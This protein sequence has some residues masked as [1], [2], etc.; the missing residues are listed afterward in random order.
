MREAIESAELL[1]PVVGSFS[2]GKS[3]LINA[4]IGRDLL[5]VGIK[6][7]T[8]LATELRHAEQERLEA[9]TRDGRTLSF[10]IEEMASLK[11]RAA[12]FS[13]LRLWI[14]SDALARIAPL[15]LVDMP[16]F[17]ST[18]ENHNKA[19]A[20][21]IEK[22]THYL[23]V[24]SVESGGIT[25]SLERQI[26]DIHELGRDFSLVLSKTNLRADS[27]VDEVVAKIEEQAE[28]AFGS[29]RTVQ[30]I[31][32][33][34][35]AQFSATLSAIEPERI[36]Q[37]LFGAEVKRTYFEITES[38]N[39]TLAALKSSSSDNADAVDAMASHLLKIERKREDLIAD[40]EARYSASAV[41]RCVEEVGRA[42][43]QNM[44]ELVEAGMSTNRDALSRAVT[45][46][47][48]GTLIRKIKSQM[49]EIGQKIVADFSLE[50]GDIDA[51]M[52]AYTSDGEWASHV[53]A[54]ASQL[55]EQAGHGFNRLGKILSDKDKAKAI[56]RVATTIVA[57]TTNVVF[58]LLELVIIFLPDLLAPFFE[59][60]RR[61]TIENTIRTTV[62]PGI[63]S[64]LHD[65]LPA[66]FKEQVAQVIGQVGAQFESAIAEKKAAIEK[67]EQ[68][69]HDHQ[70][71]L[72][73]QETQLRA[74]Q[75][76]L[77]AL[78][79]EYLD[80]GDLH[81]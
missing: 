27:E 4:F 21:Y 50:L 77:N 3:S 38:I 67:L 5:P 41:R 62:I 2:A 48:R 47:V 12:E 73:Q 1:V 80:Q 60:R 68:E 7:E 34:G 8:E 36:V 76:R 31:G 81:A 53:T 70:S 43:E 33:D 64:S 10:D 30:R 22:G 54:N 14:R 63:K 75:E 15:V 51:L 19:I 59:A 71:N 20:N 57:V 66:I 39:A 65:K 69:R 58:P 52:S 9:V 25:R 32:L 28:D 18:L 29:R 26:A 6:P 42:L 40:V 35:A 24:V 74:L 23:V 49:N 61:E 46:I 44:H 55:L 56:Y 78:T 79:H 45:E 17:D 11:A 72:D 37:S 13:H 16:G